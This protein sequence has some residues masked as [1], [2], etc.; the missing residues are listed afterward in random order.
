[1]NF[2]KWLNALFQGGNHGEISFFQLK[3]INIF[4]YKT[5]N[6]KYQIQNQMRGLGSLHPLQTLMLETSG[7]TW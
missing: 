2:S 6:K 3:K 7:K 5:T 4:F 1:M